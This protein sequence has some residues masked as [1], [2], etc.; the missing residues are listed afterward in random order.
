[1]IFVFPLVFLFVFV[2]VFVFAFVF[3]ILCSSENLVLLIIRT[4]RAGV[5]SHILAD[6]IFLTRYFAKIFS[7]LYFVLLLYLVRYFLFCNFVLFVL[8]GIF[9]TTIAG[10]S[11]HIFAD[12]IFV[13]R[14]FANYP[15]RHDIFNYYSVI[16]YLES[17]LYIARRMGYYDYA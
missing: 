14:Y 1:M 17:G 13:T 3:A 10:V 9:R 2:L 11:S 8:Q 4:T 12:M 15:R 6:M 5:S 7:F 16:L